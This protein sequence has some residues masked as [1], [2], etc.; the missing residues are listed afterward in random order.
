MAA[1]D[2]PS[3]VKHMTLKVFSK[4]KLPGP[5]KQRFASALEIA[6]SQCAKYGYTA[7]NQATAKGRSHDQQGQEGVRKNRIFD[8]M[9]SQYIADAGKRTER[10]TPGGEPAPLPLNDAHDL[11]R[12]K[13]Q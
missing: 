7:G 10:G 11:G 12:N 6:K 13:K 2:Y 1:N 8:A 3:I 9:Y 5:T 4:T